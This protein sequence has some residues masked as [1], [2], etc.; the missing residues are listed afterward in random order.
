V[1]YNLIQLMAAALIYHFS[2]LLVHPSRLAYLSPVVLSL[3]TV[4]LF[5]A[6]I[7]SA[8]TMSLL[9]I[10]LWC[11]LIIAGI[12]RKQLIISIIGF[13]S[14]TAL[15]F[16]L[17]EM[18]SAYPPSRLVEQIK[19]INTLQTTHSTADLLSNFGSFVLLAATLILLGVHTSR[20]F[21]VSSYKQTIAFLLLT[22]VIVFAASPHIGKESYIKH[23]SAA[24]LFSIGVSVHYITRQKSKQNFPLM[25]LVFILFG[26]AIT[27][28]IG[29]NNSNLL[30]FVISS[31]IVLPIAILSVK[32]NYIRTYAMI[33]SGCTIALIVILLVFFP[34]RQP[35]MYT[36]NT[37]VKP[38]V[39][40]AFLMDPTDA[41]DLDM[42]RTTL[43]EIGFQPGDPIFAP[44]RL[45]GLVYLL[46]GYSPGGILWSDTHM[47][48]YMNRLRLD[49]QKQCDPCILIAR[50][51]NEAIEF[52]S[53][54]HYNV[55]ASIANSSNHHIYKIEGDAYASEK[56]NELLK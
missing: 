4:P 15:W 11:V 43:H 51:H 24:L 29:T 14:L 52:L 23:I 49:F 18:N 45:P 30:V 28:F 46:D 2:A 37:W 42:I 50:N 34:Y 32:E 36:M 39:G 20:K 5:Y 17:M 31:G 26:A 27:S 7:S 53:F 44:F 35:P 9:I 47:P 41:T 38:P 16:A 40:S 8:L 1:A 6:K 21:A 25:I 19:T 54:T 55:T 33:T 56:T 3:I 22:A 12:R 10:G 13:S 48:A